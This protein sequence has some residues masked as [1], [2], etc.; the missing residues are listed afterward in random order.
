MLVGV[1]FFFFGNKSSWILYF[2]SSP[3]NSNNFSEACEQRKC[4]NHLSEECA[5][6]EL[7]NI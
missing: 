4:E 6:D 1:F 3:G 5:G 2:I 7:F